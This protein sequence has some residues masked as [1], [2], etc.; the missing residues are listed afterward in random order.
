MYKIS[1]WF[2]I[3][4]NLVT[5]RQQLLPSENGLSTGACFQQASYTVFTHMLAFLL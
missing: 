5:T 2:A 3:L 4:L 1:I